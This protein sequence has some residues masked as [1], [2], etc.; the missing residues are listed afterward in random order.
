MTIP[1]RTVSFSNDETGTDWRLVTA[2]E[3]AALEARTP[4][5]NTGLMEALLPV[6]SLMRNVARRGYTRDNERGALINGADR[7]DL[8]L[9]NL[10]AAVEAVP[11][12]TTE[13]AVPDNAAVVVLTEEEFA[14]LEARKPQVPAEVI[15]QAREALIDTGRIRVNAVRR[16]EALEDLLA[17]VEAV[18]E[19]ATPDFASMTPDDLSLEEVQALR[20]WLDE[21][22]RRRVRE[23]VNEVGTRW[24]C[25]LWARD[26]YGH[27]IADAEGPTEPAALRA[28]CRKV[29]AKE[30]S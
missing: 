30:A 28:L 8:L 27:K 3:L 5:V 19:V 14:A 22:G 20:D 7:L 12:T 16:R 26:T 17:A 18:P 23:L 9:A 11:G 10:F 21:R 6:V 24:S 25:D 1:K 2:K 13:D 29:A 4:Q 15:E